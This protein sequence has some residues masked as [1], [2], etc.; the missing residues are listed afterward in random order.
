MKAGVVLRYSD[1][2]DEKI[3]LQTLRKFVKEFKR[4]N[5]ITQLS[6]INSF[7]SG[8]AHGKD[9]E[10]ELL[11]E[12]LISNFIDENILEEKIKPKYGNESPANFVVFARLTIAYLARLCILNCSES[13]ELVPHGKN[14]GGYQLGLCCLIANDYSLTKKEENKL[15]SFH[16]RTI[17]KHLALQL[18]PLLEFYNPISLEN[19]IFRFQKILFETAN[20]PEFVKFL[21]KY[22]NR[23]FNLEE[24]FQNVTGISLENYRDFTIAILSILL[25]KD[26]KAENFSPVFNRQNFISKSIV[27]QEK[28]DAYLRLEGIS[29]DKLKGKLQK[30]SKI[31]TALKYQQFKVTPLVEIAPESYTA[32]DSAFIVEKLGLGGYWRIN[33]S[34]SGNDRRKF[35][36]YFGDL[37]EFYTN[38]LLKQATS[39]HPLK[40]GMFIANPEY[41]I[42]GECFDAMMYFPDGKHLLVFEHKASLLKEESKYSVSIQKLEK[43]LKEKFV[44]DKEGKARG[45]GQ[46]AKHIENLF[47]REKTKRRK[48]SDKFFHEVL[49]K[50]EKISPVIVG[51]EPFLGFHII[52]G[53]FLNNYFQKE[54]KKK[55]VSDSIKINPLTVIHIEALERL[56]PY[57]EK[58]DATFEQLLN[59]RFIRDPEYK[60]FFTPSTFFEPEFNLLKENRKNEEVLEYFSRVFD[61]SKKNLFGENYKI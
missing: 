30:P 59:L 29:I 16:P 53:A 48:L 23:S 25:P 15:N 12:R 61:E 54:L 51:L 47:H 40:C 8:F 2:F 4:I 56:K 6:I 22:P 33:D 13:S 24:K 60:S 31:P 20:S 34:L 18:A 3:S 55:D 28:F 7:L 19:G 35:K 43:E 38:N 37:F 46:L 44:V 50:V 58:G 10:I 39:K 11:Q 26:V 1:L 14:A 36:S 45:V 5:L 41:K 27:P 32:I 17:Q 42:G 49:P 52:E 21:K 57:L 9:N